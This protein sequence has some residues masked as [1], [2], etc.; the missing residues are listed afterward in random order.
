MAL[1]I[2]EIIERLRPGDRN[3]PLRTSQLRPEVGEPLDTTKPPKPPEGVFRVEREFNRFLQEVSPELKR[4]IEA[5]RLEQSQKQELITLFHR[6]RRSSLVLSI[7]DKDRSWI[8][9]SELSS[10]SAYTD[11]KIPNPIVIY[12][13]N[14]MSQGGAAQF[15]PAF[16]LNLKKRVGLKIT[17]PD[18]KEE[19]VPEIMHEAY[20]LAGETHL[21]T[22]GISRY[23]YFGKTSTE[24]KVLIM[25]YFDTHE[26]PT[27]RQIIDRDPSIPLQ[28]IERILHPEN[29]HAYVSSILQT[30]KELHTPKV[31]R[32][33]GG[34][35]VANTL[36]R[37]QY[38]ELI[39]CDIKPENILVHI[40]PLLKNEKLI[41]DPNNHKTVLLDFGLAS[42]AHPVEEG[43]VRGSMGYSS[44]NTG[45]AY[46]CSAVA[47]IL[48][49]LIT[50]Q[51]YWLSIDPPPTMQNVSPVGIAIQHIM[52]GSVGNLHEDKIQSYCKKYG[53]DFESV[54]IFFEMALP[55]GSDSGFANAAEFARSF[56]QAFGKPDTVAFR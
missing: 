26:Y 17:R 42:L 47:I 16:C 24:E 30:L 40:L 54:L 32:V 34:G 13:K 19:E 38:M 9:N 53:L 33:I 15:L 41:N 18:R 36:Q 7:V 46:D 10:A 28:V 43:D 37:G 39:H 4:A 6:E 50:G 20:T 3:T 5:A 55:K 45:A 31:R 48:H 11:R 51:N 14:M 12:D 44:L 23:Y 2:G 49:E 25:E 27:L 8:L 1:R 22:P 35:N 56:N 21:G 29:L 52:L